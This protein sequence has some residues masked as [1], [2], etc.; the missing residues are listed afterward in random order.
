MNFLKNICPASFD[1]FEFLPSIGAYG[2][3]IT[4]WKSSKFTGT[5]SFMNEYSLSAELTSSQTGLKW[6][7][8][9]VYGPCEHERKPQF[10]EWLKNIEMSNETDWLILG[11][12]NLIRSPENRNKPGG[13]SSEMFLFNEAISSLGLVEIP[14]KGGKYTWSNKQENLL[15]QRL[16]WF[17]T[18]SNLVTTYPS[19]TA[20]TL[21]RDTSDH[22]L[23]VI[24]IQTSMPRAK[25]FRFENFWME[26]DDFMSVVQHAWS[27]PVYQQDKAKY[28]T[29]KFKNQ[30]R[31]L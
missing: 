15:L 13:N 28:L 31:V 19:T 9:N 2:W 16:D 10:I 5:V 22:V 27:I 14:L 26:H 3:C 8:T 6:I 17:F 11:D 18:N 1:C 23:C 30:R 24:A 25:V 4:I 7:L 20:Q 12:F 21:S 29:A